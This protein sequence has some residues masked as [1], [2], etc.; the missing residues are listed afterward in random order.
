MPVTCS[1]S[2]LQQDTALKW[3]GITWSSNSAT[4][5][6]LPYPKIFY[7][8]Q[9]TAVEQAGNSV[10]FLNLSP[11]LTLEAAILVGNRCGRT[12][13]TRLSR[14]GSEADGQ[15]TEDLLASAST[16]TDAVNAENR[17]PAHASWKYGCHD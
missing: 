4:R 12:L 15:W 16:S 9:K 13:F 14:Q 6:I 17:V 1:L 5:C 10:S 8:L 11:T 7:V 2:S 3:A